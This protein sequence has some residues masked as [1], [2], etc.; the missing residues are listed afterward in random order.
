[1]KDV[2]WPMIVGCA[3]IVG[4]TFAVVRPGRVSVPGD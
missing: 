2:T 1:V 4:G 3:L